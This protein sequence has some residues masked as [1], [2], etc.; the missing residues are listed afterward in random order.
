MNARE[1]SEEA[2]RARTFGFTSLTFWAGLGFVLESAHALKWSHYLDHPL[3]R[4]LLTWA[5]AHGVGL[6]LVVLVYGVAGIHPALSS[7]AGSRLRAGAVLMPLGFLLSVLGISESDPGPAIFAVPIGALLGLSSLVE[8][9][10]A[11][12]SER[13]ESLNA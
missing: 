4:E 6:A 12:R 5:H 7:S 2:L 9:A 8:I 10:L 3:R 11:L 13:V 1:R